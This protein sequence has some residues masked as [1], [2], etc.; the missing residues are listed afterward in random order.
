MRAP[1]VSILMPVRDAATTLPSALRSIARQTLG[2][3]E[4]VAVD[5]GSSDV[6]HAVLERWAQ[7]DTRFQV[8]RTARAGIVS[9]LNTGLAACRGRF[10]AR[11]D[12]D[13][14][15]HR[16]RLFRQLQALDA[17]PSLAGVGC[18]VRLFPRAG[19]KAGRA[20][21]AAW[22]N[23]LRSAAELSRDRF[24]EC[25]LAHPTLFLRS[26]VLVRFGY[27]ELGWAED[28]DLVLRVLAAGE[29]LGVVTEALL[30]WRDSATRLSRTSP[31]YAQTRFVA[32]KAAFL[33]DSWLDS[34]GYVL[35]GYGDTGRALCRALAELG[36]R[37]THIVELHPGR[38][39]QRVA[40][41]LVIRPEAL[42][43]LE[44]RPSRIVVSVASAGARAEIRASLANLGFVEERDYVC[45]A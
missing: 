21:Y 7:L 20:T 17:D 10:I 41:A 6:T 34:S 44:P 24:V 3:F 28:Y 37:P 16:D 12:A 40:G 8:V 15:M 25:P 13:D 9:A 33:H 2:D 1:L 11:M 38:I 30:D 31:V 22:L 19:Q 14:R 26:E 32:C 4:C 27:R 23:S 5:D 29:R 36:R 18:H 35:W 45:A 42:L 39:G 43:G